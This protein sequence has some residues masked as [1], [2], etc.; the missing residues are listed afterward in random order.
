MTASTRTAGRSLPATPR[1]ARVVRFLEN[2]GLRACA[3]GNPASA[4]SPQGFGSPVD[5]HWN[6]STGGDQTASAGVSGERR[7]A[8]ARPR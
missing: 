1:V 5:A 7:P 8:V 4:V 2:N 6:E 3:S